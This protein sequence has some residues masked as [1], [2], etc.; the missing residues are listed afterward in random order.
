MRSESRQSYGWWA[1]AFLWFVIGHLYWTWPV[2][3]IPGATLPGPMGDNAMMLWNL[4]WMKHAL[5]RAQ[6][7]FW[8][9]T[10]FAP[11]GF[12]FLYGSHTWLD[13][14]LCWATSW[15]LPSG[16][17]SII[18]WANFN[19]L[20]STVATGLV[21]VAVLRVWGIT[22]WPLA[23]MGASA[24]TFSW[25]RSYA[26]AGHYNLFGTHWML[27]SLAFL[28]YARAAWHDGQLEPMR[29][30]SMYGGVL[31]GLAALNDQTLAIFTAALACLILLA[32]RDTRSRNTGW[33]KHAVKVGVVY[34]GAAATVAAVHLVP[35]VYYWYKGRLSYYIVDSEVG[36][37]VDASSLVVPNPHHFAHRWIKNWYEARGLFFSEGTY[38][39]VITLALFVVCLWASI[40][41]ALSRAERF[42]LPFFGFG[43]S[44]VLLCLSLG[45]SL[46]VGSNSYFRL[47]GSFSKESPLVNNLRV[48]QRW[49]WPFHLVIVV[50]GTWFV[51]QWASS[52]KAA[53]QPQVTARSRWYYLPILLALLPVLEGR[54]RPYAEPADYSA[55]SQVHPAGLVQGIIENHAEGS[56]L[57]MPVEAA[58]AEANILQTLVGHQHHFALG[59]VA[60]PPMGEPPWKWNNWSG[61]V[62]A[63]LDSS[64]VTMLVF[65]FH[66]GKVDEFSDWIRN[67]RIARPELIVLNRSGEII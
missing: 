46:Q 23:I 1:F 6:P 63:W 38:L 39:G 18:L 43:A 30:R 2:W 7:G 29:R 57:V 48:P 14:V 56:V 17:N 36:R 21:A 33:V 61:D 60:R 12:L 10:L 4:G 45:D 42:R 34:F 28:S 16:Y 25:F 19:L 24:V 22:H 49:V 65:P 9:N 52:G 47:P 3:S 5:S 35:I 62:G 55:G 40:R 27:A 41:F 44:L 37:L 51:A 8:C 31:L 15:V 20:F 67:A 11:D 58:R 26:L 64:N 32:M 54:W 66:E 59:Y 13:G 53:W 50:S